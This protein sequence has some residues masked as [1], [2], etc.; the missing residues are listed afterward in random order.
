M[1]RHPFAAL[2]AMA[3]TLGSGPAA[4]AECK[5]QM[6]ASIPISFVNKQPMVDGSI[7]GKPIRL[8]FRIGG[9]IVL[10]G[11]VLKDF[12]LKEA[13]G[14]SLG[15][16]YG[17]GGAADTS[18][19]QIHDLKVGDF[20]SK[21][22][23]Y[24]VVPG[25]QNA[26]E[27]GVFGSALFDGHNDVELDFAHDVV[28]VFKADG[29]KDD[30][31]VYWGGAYSVVATD[32]FGFVPVKSAGK[33]LKAAIAAGNEATLVTLDGARRA[34]VVLKAAGPLPTGMITG[35]AIKPIDVSIANFPELV[36]GDETIMNAPL[37]VGDLYPDRPAGSTPAVVLGADF[38]RPYRY[39]SPE[40]RPDVVLG[41]DFVR[42]HRI[43][44][45]AQQGKVYFSYVGG[46]LFADIY[47]RLG[48]PAPS[49]PPNAPKP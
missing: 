6:L 32:R 5:L 14:Y 24:Y 44:V 1:N 48:V 25:V 7:N 8:R 27:A 40:S 39:Q 11:S 47:A 46:P 2:V 21:D 28:R 3:L 49:A 42:S 17:A 31:V 18:A 9:N 13:A 10:W 36:I 20:A 19:V 45:S 41:A 15:T 38:V 12:G 4:R 22:A 35:G 16:T 30:T 23:Y 29:C 33:T 37:A 34:G 26:G 43:Y